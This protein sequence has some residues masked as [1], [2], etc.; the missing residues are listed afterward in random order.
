MS[1]T[2]LTH[3]LLKFLVKTR[4]KEVMEGHNLRNIFLAK[5][6]CISPV[7]APM[8]GELEPEK[9]PAS[10]FCRPQPAGV[11]SVGQAADPQPK[12]APPA[13]VALAGPPHTLP[14]WPAWRRHPWLCCPCSGPG[15]QQPSPGQ[16]DAL[17]A[18]AQPARVPNVAVGA[19][20]S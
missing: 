5:L 16:G 1:S 17:R 15:H 12:A 20:L 11:S 9:K 3:P 19:L 4:W 2:G 6:L 10:S 18:L 13:R 14:T 7:T 8:N